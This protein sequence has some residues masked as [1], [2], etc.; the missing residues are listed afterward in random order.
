MSLDDETKMAQS[1]NSICFQVL[2]ERMTFKAVHNQ[3]ACPNLSSDNGSVS[4][5]I[6]SAWFRA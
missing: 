4:S 6:S 1:K 3:K 5:N 2:S